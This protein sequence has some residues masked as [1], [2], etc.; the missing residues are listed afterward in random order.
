M[1]HIDMRLKGKYQCYADLSNEVKEVIHEMVESIHRGATG[2]LTYD[3]AH[4]IV[5]R[6]ID[7]YMG[8]NRSNTK[9]RLVQ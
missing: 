5:I 9:I 2:N 3:E 6:G 8:V 1:N 4:K 7:S